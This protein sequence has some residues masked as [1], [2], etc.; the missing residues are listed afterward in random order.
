MS[1]KKVW[2]ITG[3]GRGIGVEIAKAAL[4]AGHA[5]VATGRNTD[6]VT[7]ALG[8]S[9]DLLVAKLDITKK[10][11]ADAAA[12]ATL[13]RFGRIDVLVNNA[14]N[15]YAGF[16]EELSMEQIEK[17]IVTGLLGQMIV[18]RAIL[19]QMRKQRS[20]HI[21][22][23]SSSAGVVGGEFCTA[24]AAAKFGVEGWIESL[25]LEIGQFG[26]NTTLVN[27]GFFR[28][29]LLSDQSTTFTKPSIPD[30]AEKT[31]QYIAAWK[32]MNG[33]QPG[34]PAKL[35]RALIKIASEKVPP[36]RFVAGADAVAAIVKKAEALKAEATAYGAL[37]ANM[38]FE[39]TQ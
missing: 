10:E 2:L 3:A 16:F 12:K 14:S 19:P 23:I 18:T 24:Y 25:Q 36:R 35:A 28:S 11:D 5:V 26:I 9:K 20:G 33:K 8:Q 15:F 1:A 29:E 7:E 32:S 38:G 6:A 37:S 34:N 13:D 39:N 21:I 30:Y 31:E 27:P 22:T 17:Q 4:T